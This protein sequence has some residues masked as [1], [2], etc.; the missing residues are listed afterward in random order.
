[1]PNKKKRT[2]GISRYF[3]SSLWIAVAG[4]AAV[5]I[6][7]LLGTFTDIPLWIIGLSVLLLLVVSF[8]LILRFFNRR[9]PHGADSQLL[10]PV[11]GNIMLDTVMKL[12]SPV[13]ICD[14]KEER[15]IWYNRALSV[16]CD[17]GAQTHG[18]SCHRS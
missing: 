11:L 7:A 18:R 6:I 5:A 9:G 12:K 16:V 15:I 13:F 2:S 14:E 3:G 10:S 1:M 4:V 8:A 17:T